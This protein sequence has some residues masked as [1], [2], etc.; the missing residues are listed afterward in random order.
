MNT[1][2]RYALLPIW[3]HWDSIASLPAN[4]IQQDE[5]GDSGFLIFRLLCSVVG[6]MI[7]VRACQPLK[8]FP[9]KF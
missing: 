4:R 6:T 7:F 8:P 1:V 3:P 2:H 5:T 9:F